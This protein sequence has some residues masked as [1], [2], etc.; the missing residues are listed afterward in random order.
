MKSRI[1]SAVLVTLLV[2]AI[3]TPSV[4]AAPGDYVDTSEEDMEE[5]IIIRD[6]GTSTEERPKLPAR[7]PFTLH[8]YNSDLHAWIV[9]IDEYET[10]K[11]LVETGYHRATASGYMEEGTGKMT[12]A[13]I[14]EM[15]M[16]SLN[17]DAQDVSSEEEEAVRDFVDTFRAKEGL[18]DDDMG[19]N[20]NYLNKGTPFK[21]MKNLLI[22]LRDARRQTYNRRLSGGV[23]FGDLWEHENHVDTM[24]EM[25]AGETGRRLLD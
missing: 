1:S 5:E 9:P 17:P 13:G 20:V 18:K 23:G 2:L 4:M 24:T 7:P 21:S 14:Y 19:L 10:L 6:D 3:F 8:D 22:K 16:Y 15:I 11:L 25:P 12:A